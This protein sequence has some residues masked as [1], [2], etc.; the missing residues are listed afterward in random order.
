M[1]LRKDTGLFSGDSISFTYDTKGRIAT[2][3]HNDF[4]ITLTITYNRK[5]QITSVTDGTNTWNWT[6]NTK[7]QITSIIKA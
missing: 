2:I 4:S 1:N 5:N 6:R 7:D 3:V